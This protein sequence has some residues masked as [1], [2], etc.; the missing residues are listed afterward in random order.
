[1][2]ASLMLQNIVTKDDVFVKYRK[3][4]SGNFVFFFSPFLYIIHKNIFINLSVLKL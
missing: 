4:I 1:M 3:I 2:R